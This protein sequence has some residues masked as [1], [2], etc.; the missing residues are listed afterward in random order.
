MQIKGQ[1]ETSLYLANI[2]EEAAHHQPVTHITLS[3]ENTS[4]DSTKVI[5]EALKKSVTN[6][7]HYGRGG[8]HTPQKKIVA[9]NVFYAI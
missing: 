7:T 3:S 9:Q 4:L 2:Q 5:R 8:C 6:V 1:F